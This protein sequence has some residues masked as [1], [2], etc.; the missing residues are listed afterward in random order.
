MT[1]PRPRMAIGLQRLLADQAERDGDYRAALYHHHEAD[2]LADMDRLQQR[3]ERLTAQI[4]AA[5]RDLAA[6]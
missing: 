2:W 3:N 6:P 1:A 4:G 5:M